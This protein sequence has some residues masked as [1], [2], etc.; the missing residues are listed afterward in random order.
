MQG[1]SLSIQK[2]RY[3]EHFYGCKLQTTLNKTHQLYSA[4]KLQLPFKIGLLCPNNLLHIN[5]SKQGLTNHNLNAQAISTHQATTNI[6]ITIQNPFLLKHFLQRNI[7]LAEHI[8]VCVFVDKRAYT[9]I[10]CGERVMQ[11]SEG[12][13]K[14]KNQKKTI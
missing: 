11:K 14:K 13:N 2:G 5:S 9:Y 6:P 10:D 12:A 3:D 7:A 4:C 1:I 8:Y